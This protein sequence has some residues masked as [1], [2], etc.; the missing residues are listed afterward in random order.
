MQNLTVALKHTSRTL[1]NLQTRIPFRYGF[2]TLT[3]FP[4]LVLEATF[5]INDTLQKGWS[6]ESLIAKWFTKDPDTEF[7]DDLVDMLAVIRQAGVFAVRI[8]TAPSLFTWWWDLYHIQKRWGERHGY[9]ALLWNLGVSLLER[10]AIDAY[11]RAGRI[12]FAAGLR[13]NVYGIQLGQVHPILENSQPVDWLPALPLEQIS[14]R[15]TVGLADCLTESEI[16]QAERNQD[17]LPRSLEAAIAAYQL[18]YFK[19]KLSGDGSTDLHRLAQIAALLHGI[20][21]ADYQFTLDGNEQFHQSTDFL[22]FWQSLLDATTLADFLAHLLYVE[23]PLHRSVALDER[24][25]Q[26]FLNWE[27]RPPI[28][29]DES[30][31]DLTSLVRAIEC[32]YV[33]TSHKNCKGVFKGIAN[34]CLLEALRRQNPDQLFLL[35]GEDLVNVGPLALQQDLAVMASLGIVHV[36]RNGQHYFNGLSGFPASAQAAVLACHPDLYREHPAGYPV[37][38]IEDGAISTQ[39]INTAPF[40]LCVE[41]DTAEFTPEEEWEFTSLGLP[42]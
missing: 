22:D 32:G 33:G 37:L 38:R 31:S 1:H 34:A 5:E 30:D 26:A 16:P 7:S 29:I 42:I 39:S 2:A 36:E 3:A 20:G 8:G 35:S 23:Q 40:G 19:I 12:T 14:V 25:R 4:H 28:I 11:C 18:R 6:A 13:E 9:Q 10:A 27:A 24:T 41:F 17:D 15:H 21:L